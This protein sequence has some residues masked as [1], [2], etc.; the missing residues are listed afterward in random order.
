MRKLAWFAAGFALLCG[1]VCHGPEGTL[2]PA[3]LCGGALAIAALTVLLLTR[4]DPARPAGFR[5]A[6]RVLAVGL[7]GLVAA[8]WFWGWST[9]FRAPAEAMAGSTRTLSATV[10]SYPAETSIGGYSVTVSLDGGI[11]APD[12]LVYATAGWGDLRPGDHL[13]FTARLAPSDFVKGDETTYYT[14]KNIFL[15][16][17]CDEGPQAVTRP[18]RL[19]LRVIPTVCAHALRE[20]LAAVFDEPAASLAAAITL[21]DKSGLSNEVLSALNRSGAAHTVAVSGM[22]LSFLV[23]VTLMLTRR[24][25]RFAVWCI[26]LLL[27]YALM[28]GASPSALRAVIMQGVLLFAP[29]AKREN[30]SPTSL[31]F[32]LLLLL[33]L[34]PYSFASVSLQLSFASVAGILLITETQ[35]HG[36]LRP[37]KP[38][39]KQHT[40]PWWDLLLRLARL[41]EV[42][43]ATSLGA[44]FFA[45]PLVS[46]YYGAFS[47]VFPLTNLLILWAVSV[48]FIAALLLGTLG[49]A[50]PALAGAVAPA[51]GLLARYILWAVTT[52]G[53][54]RFAAVDTTNFCYLLCLIAIYL[55][56]AVWLLFGRKDLRLP[57]PLACF[58]LLI[59]AAFFCSRTPVVP[60]DLTVTALDVGQGASAALI[61]DGSTCLVDCGGSGDNAGDAAA[62][63]FAG[64]GIQQLDLLVLTHFDADHFNG[65][66]QLFARMDIDQVAIP[67]VGH[68]YEHMEALLTLCQEEGTVVTYVTELRSFSLGNAELTLYPPL[69]SGTSNEEGLF[70]LGSAGD[71]DV[72]ITGDADSFVEKM[73]IRY[74]NVPD[75]ELLLAGHH[76]S[77]GS[78]CEELLDAVQP[79]LAIISVGYNSYGHPSDKTLRR[80]EERDV[81]IYRTDLHGSVT[82]QVRSDG[83]AAQTQNR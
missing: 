71:F 51:A 42:S 61:S 3:A 45:E 58:V 36:M 59:A 80:L 63:Y 30:D 35:A 67:D 37:L 2:L 11:T 72:L 73:L 12:V 53:Q 78:T 14:A 74:Y 1:A 68:S 29:I 39:A 77:S 34:N 8:G 46:Y 62:D 57:I 55:F 28:A 41:A 76:G 64:M 10:L 48:F 20:S 21:G 32:A 54:W 26:P 7:G 22:H 23:A 50:L 18:E 6:R 38:L 49:L 17:Y 47:L 25:R 4:R 66:E 75:I 27:F 24:K 33:L 60:R 52:V 5:V 31:S 19:P 69:G 44:M 79:E 9:L 65:V 70:V 16:G 56:V 82:I 83:Y 13:T 40:G 15:L 81:R 43:V